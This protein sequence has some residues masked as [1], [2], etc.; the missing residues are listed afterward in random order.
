MWYN[1]GK[2]DSQLMLELGEGEGCSLK[3]RENWKEIWTQCFSALE[4]SAYFK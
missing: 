4:F 3:K 1:H 2:K